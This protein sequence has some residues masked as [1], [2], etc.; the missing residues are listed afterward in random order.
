MQHMRLNVEDGE[1]KSLSGFRKEE[2]SSSRGETW[3]LY[4][5]TPEQFL[6]T[7]PFHQNFGI[8][9]FSSIKTSETYRG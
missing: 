5:F 1:L 8:N 2:K 7:R 9:C 6:A 3:V 4:F